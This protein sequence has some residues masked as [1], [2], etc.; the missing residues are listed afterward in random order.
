MKKWLI[1][2]CVCLISAIPFKMVSAD[3]SRQ[4]KSE[5]AMDAHIRKVYMLVNFSGHN[6]LAYDV[7]AKAYQGYLN[8][9]IAGK[10]NTD[11]EIISICDFNL[12]STENRL[13]IID[14]AAKKVLFNVLVAHGQGSGDVFAEHFSNSLNSHQSS[15]GFYVTGDTYQGEHGLSLRLMGMDAGFNDAALDRGIVVHGAAYVSDQFVSGNERLGR[16]WGCPAIS[17]KLKIPVINTIQGGTCLFI[18]HTD[19]QYEQTAYWMNKKPDH[20]PDTDFANPF[21]A[22]SK[23]VSTADLIKY[24]AEVTSDS[25]AKRHSSN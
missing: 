11:K 22:S 16:S 5:N 19:K 14:L 9:R 21:T 8:L 25:Q 18:Y 12:P 13:W 24:A 20:L 23:D 6:Q 1:F 10:I 7:F 15:L 2:I 4:E 3:E 17:E